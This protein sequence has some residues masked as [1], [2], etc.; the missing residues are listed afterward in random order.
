MKLL[1]KILVASVITLVAANPAANAAPKLTLSTT[2]LN[3]A[4][5][6]PQA[7]FSPGQT[8]AIEVSDQIPASAKNQRVMFSASASFFV[9]GLQIPIKLS[10]TSSAESMVA[11]GD[12]TV[13]GTNV[14]GVLGQIRFK[15]PKRVPSGALQVTVAVTVRG[16]GTTVST[17]TIPVD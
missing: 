10:T 1:V 6:L 4:T 12:P 3:A 14:Q 8:V 7:S 9:L 17:T 5:Q 16:V 11:F 13:S 2:V 15:V